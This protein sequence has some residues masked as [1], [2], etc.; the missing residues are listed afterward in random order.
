MG[1][2]EGNPF[3]GAQAAREW[4]DCV[5]NPG[6]RV[7]DGDIYP[8][9]KEWVLNASP[10]AVLEIGCG[11][12]V[13]SNSIQGPAYTGIDLSPFLLD[14]A[15]QLYSGPGKKFIQGSADELPLRDEIFDAAFSVSVWHLLEDLGRAAHE[16]SRVLKDD[17]HFLIISANPGAYALWTDR[18][19]ESKREGRRLEG[20]ISNP[21]GTVSREVLF[22]HTLGEFKDALQAAG[23]DVLKIETFRIISNGQQQYVCIRGRKGR[24]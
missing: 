16:M 5:E 24:V 7:R 19:T 4:I 17:G 8:M 10:S 22:L 6:S 21:D 3:D 11:Q 15:R 20:A 2:D 14:R 23:L 13:C 9:L 12:G 1:Q 18:Y